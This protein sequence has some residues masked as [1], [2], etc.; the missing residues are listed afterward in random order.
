MTIEIAREIRVPV[1]VAWTELAALERH[2]EWMGDAERIMFRG[3]QRRGVGT[4]MEVL[5]RVG[6]FRTRDVMVVDRWEDGRAIGVAHRGLVSGAG[7]FLL[8]PTP[9]GTRIVWRERLHFPWYLGGRL[10]ALLARPVLAMVWRENLE[11]LAARLA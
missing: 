3:E 5:T 4:T 2:S 7:V 6:P 9:E 1:P 10:T 11:R 8:E